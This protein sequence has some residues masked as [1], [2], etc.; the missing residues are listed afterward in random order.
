MEVVRFWVAGLGNEGDGKVV[1]EGVYEDYD[2]LGEGL[3]V[4]AA[5]VWIA[6]D[7]VIVEGYGWYGAFATIRED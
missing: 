3:W 2:G 1:A 7:V 4:P 6:W 5:F